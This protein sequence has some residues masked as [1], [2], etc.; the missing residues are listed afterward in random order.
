[1]HQIEFNPKIQ[2]PKKETIK[3]HGKYLMITEE[4]IDSTLWERCYMHNGVIVFPQDD[5]G[6]IYLIQEKRPHENPS[7]RWK[8]VTGLLDTNQT[9]Q[10][11][12]NR[13]LQEELGYKAH[14]WELFH[15]MNFTGSV[16]NTA[17]FFLAKG[18]EPCKIPNPD[19]DV[20]LK[21][22]KFSVDEIF[23]KVM[24]GDIPWSI[25]TLGIFKLY[26]LQKNH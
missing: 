23:H 15:Q 3:F 11:S 19:G 22:E 2:N 1:M 17:Y 6:K 16:N 14:S 7:I 12:A 5:D 9:P 10:E 4:L 21:M 24:Q 26:Y 18:L 13:E 25:S 8:M 20:I